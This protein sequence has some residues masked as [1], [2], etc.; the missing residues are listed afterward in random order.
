MTLGEGPT[1]VGT[2]SWRS[3]A[4][5]AILRN[6]VETRTLG[7]DSVYSHLS[8]PA[9][10]PT[11]THILKATSGTAL[12]WTTYIDAVNALLEGTQ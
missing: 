2:D 8:M 12:W 1:Y 9:G 7:Y 3:F 4:S 11:H 6:H 5:L 10:L